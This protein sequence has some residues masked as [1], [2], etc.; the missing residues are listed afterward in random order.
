METLSSNNQKYY[1]LAFRLAIATILFNL[2]EGLVSLFFGFRDES[3]SLFG[4]GG[5]SIIEVISGFGILSMLV[6]SKGRDDKRNKAER[7]ALKITGFGFYALVLGL[8]S[9]CIYDILGQHKPSTTLA[10]IV[11]ST[12][13]ICGM[14]ILIILKTKAGN[15]LNSKALLADAACSRICIYMSVVVLVS[16][17]IFYYTHFAFADTIGSLGLSYF[18]LK[19]GL[20][21]FEKLKTNEVCTCHHD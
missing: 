6:R 4:F 14:Y 15:A 18:A 20:E 10:G 19:E 12:I 21:C 16:S 2:A 3:F 9:S 5:G 13:S 17:G 1:V 8:V 7:L 11:I